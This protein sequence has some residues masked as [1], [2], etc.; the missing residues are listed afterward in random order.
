MGTDLN[1]ANRIWAATKQ[2]AGS[3]GHDR[4]HVDYYTTTL[5][6]MTLLTNRKLAEEIVQETYEE[7]K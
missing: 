2:Q 4:N 3:L 7:E 5:V 6:V 1:L